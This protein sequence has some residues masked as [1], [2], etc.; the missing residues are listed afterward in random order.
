MISLCKRIT[1]LPAILLQ[2]YMYHCSA[3]QY[4]NSILLVY[5]NTI[6]GILLVLCDRNK[7]EYF[8]S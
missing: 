8:V 1:S 4:I 3:C 2:P 5:S 6:M 7:R